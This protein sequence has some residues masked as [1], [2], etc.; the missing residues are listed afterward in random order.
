[1][2]A[3]LREECE[4]AKMR[5]TTEET[6]TIR[7]PDAD[8][9][10]LPEAPTYAVSREEFESL[11]GD[12]MNRLAAPVDRAL[13]DAGCT[14]ADIGDAILVGG[15]TRMPIL[16]RF[17]ASYCGTQPLATHNP[18]EVVALGAAVQAALIA[19]DAAVGDIVMTD[20]CPFSL[21][22]G[23]A[24]QFGS[25]I[26]DGYYLPIIHRNTTIPVSREESVATVH[27]NQ[28]EMLIEIFQGEARKTEM[29]LLLGRLKV[30]GIP[31]GPAGYPV[32]VRFTYDING[33]LDVE[34]IVPGTG[35]TF[36]AVLTSNVKGLSAKELEKAVARMKEVKFFPR[37]E[38][39]NQRLLL[40][41]ERATAEL[42]PAARQALED[43]L[44][45]FELAMSSGDRRLFDE[46]RQALLVTLSA[47]GL[48]YH[49]G[50][51]Q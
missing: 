12:L 13:R 26:Q 21:G 31:P 45:R 34:A 10:I 23:I 46:S 48:E 49:E 6:A 36:E 25:R 42:D 15:A 50:E 44:D 39:R 38:A 41:C 43:S 35:R 14:A 24:K 9:R 37:D 47:L 33:I 22:I 1:M 32:H 27:P 20:V 11:V 7:I 5:L 19:D 2:F 3:R 4:A 51:A 28:R 18:D 30:K 8:G 29:N 17:V 40:F 16:R